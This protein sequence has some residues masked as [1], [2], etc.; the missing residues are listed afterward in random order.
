MGICYESTFE[1]YCYRRKDQTSVPALLVA[2]SGSSYFS[3][4]HFQIYYAVDLF[5]ILRTYVVCT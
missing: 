2:H 3:E 1:N 5:Q 4:K